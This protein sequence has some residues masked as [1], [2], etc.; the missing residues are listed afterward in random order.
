MG[1]D[2]KPTGL[3]LWCF[4]GLILLGVPLGFFAIL[5]LS[6]RILGLGYPTAFLLSRHHDDQQVFVQNN[7]FGWRFFGRQMSRLP[8]PV[9]IANPKFPGTVRI[10]VFGESAA[11]GDPRPAFGLSRMLAALMSLRHPG[12]RFEVVNAAMTAINSHTILPIARDCAGA[13]GDLWVIYMGNNEVVGP[14]GAGTVFGRPVPPLP[15]IRA[16]LALKS[17]RVGQLLDSA[18]QWFQKPPPEK[19]E[20]GGMTMFLDHQV[21]G[22]DPRMLGVYNHFQK[23]LVDILQLGTRHGCGIVLSTVAVNLKDCAPFASAHRPGL[24]DV[25]QRQFEELFQKS[26]EAQNARQFAAAAQSFA[27]AARIDDTWAE[28]RFRQGTCALALNQDAEAR[29][30]F[31]AA[32]D[33]DVL[34]FR[35]DS[36][37]NQLIRTTI[38]DTKLENLRMADAERAFAEASPQGVPGADLFYEHVHLTFEGNYLLGRTIA[39]QLEGLLPT[40]IAPDA[41]KDK[42]WP[43]I[44]DCATRLGWNPAECRAAYSEMLVRLAD[45]PFTTQ[46][47]HELQVAHLASRSQPPPAAQAATEQAQALKSCEEATSH[48]PDDPY[49][50]AE[51]ASLKQSAGDPAGA[52]MAMR[53]S[54][55]L[56]PSSSEAWSRLGSLLVQ[57]HQFADA[58]AAFRSEFALDSQDVSALQNLAMCLMKQNQPDNAIREYRRALAIKPRFGPAW[59]GLGLALESQGRNDEALECFHKALANRIHTGSGLA[60]LARFCATRG[61]FGAAATNYT[62]ALKLSAPDAQLN[63]EAGQVFGALARHPE[64]AQYYATAAA[65]APDWAQAQFQCGL[66]LGQSGH[67]AEAS[68]RFKEAIRLMPDLIEARLNLGVAL[69][70]QNRPAEALDQ[71][72]QVLQRS[73]TNALA[74]QYVQSLRQKISAKP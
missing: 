45:P 58:A 59:L 62:D 32:R 57:Q 40:S 39:T 23:N 41:A 18:R 30:Q 37:L 15:V 26:V 20:W 52:V 61:W 56:L 64:A 48:Y 8:C 25:Q 69:I 36:H 17:L 4:R 43:S 66:E 68:A 14:F 1:A 9:S 5:E 22:Q 21:P 73:P 49:L 50:S 74:Q 65:L 28:L 55:E 12:V 33:L 70:N 53:R 11:Y 67:P 3:R 10:F 24:S 35:C 27:D 46:A 47:N 54:L 34:R 29:A 60:T 38:S 6:F 63:Y 2:R 31:G 7:Q 16:N 51:L 72:E 71:F 42:P 19:T 13:Q 44:A